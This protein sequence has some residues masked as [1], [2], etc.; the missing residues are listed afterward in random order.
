MVSE[1]SASPR[2][3][4]KANFSD[5][6]ASRTILAAVGTLAN[7]LILSNISCCPSMLICALCHGNLA[8]SIEKFYEKSF[9]TGSDRATSVACPMEALHLPRCVTLALVVRKQ[10]AGQM[11]GEKVFYV[12]TT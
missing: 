6:A 11:R 5:A 9:T 1:R 4:N 10:L 3:Q 2:W 12:P 7:N 8:L